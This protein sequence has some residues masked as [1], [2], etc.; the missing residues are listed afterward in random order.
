MVNFETMDTPTAFNV[1]LVGDFNFQV[2][3]Q[4][5]QQNQQ[6]PLAK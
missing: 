3:F 6:Q 1:V 5:L 4:K 2:L